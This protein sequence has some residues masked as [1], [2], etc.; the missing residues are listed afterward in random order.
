MSLVIEKIVLVIISII[1][2]LGYG[3]IVLLMGLESAN[4]PIPS[5]VILPFA[6]F[7]AWQGRM[8]LHLAAL[9]GALGCLWGSIVSYWLGLYLGRPLVEKYGKWV[10]VSKKDLDLADHWIAKYGAVVF[11]FSRLLPVVRTFISLGAGITRAKFWRFC[12]YT[13]IGSWIW[14]YVLIYIGVKAGEQWQQIRI[15]WEKFDFLIIG[16]AVILVIWYVRRHF[17]N[18]KTS[19]FM[20]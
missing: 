12:F 13:F 11:F 1:A 14:S 15:I 4:I 9:A 5:E 16:L 17:K 2:K 6:G 3:G 19:V 18:D 20:L 10:L 7:L 8:N